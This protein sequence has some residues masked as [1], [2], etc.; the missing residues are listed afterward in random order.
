MRTFERYFAEF[1]ERRAKSAWDAYTPYELRNVGAFVRLGW[2]DRAGELLEFFM[3]GRRPAEWNGWAEVVGREPRKP[4][5]VGD[6]PHAWVGADFVR[7][8]LDVFAWERESDG[9]LVLAAGIPASWLRGGSPVG[10]TRLRTPH[11]LLDY[12]LRAEKKGLLVNIGP[13]EVPR[14]GIALRPPLDFQPHRVTVN[15]KAVAFSGE[16][17]VIRQLPATILFASAS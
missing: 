5:F 1:R 11:G 16:E 15:G 3:K 2:R 4:R 7:S 10:V 17:L 8:F 14:G 9:A 13:L 6:M 12:T